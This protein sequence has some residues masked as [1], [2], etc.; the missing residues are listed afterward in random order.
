MCNGKRRIMTL[1][2]DWKIDTSEMSLILWSL[3]A[4]Y[5]RLATDKTKDGKKHYNRTK[6]LHLKLWREFM[7]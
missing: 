7:K 3:E 6:A 5:K 2:E 1:K 4:T